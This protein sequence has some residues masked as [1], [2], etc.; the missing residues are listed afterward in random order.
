MGM[1]GELFASNWRAAQSVSFGIPLVPAAQQLLFFLAQV[2]RYRCLYGGPAVSRAIQRYEECWLPLLA[3]FSEHEATLP[4]QPPLDCAWIWHVHRLNPITYARDCNLLFGRLLDV[5]PNSP[6]VTDATETTKALWQERFPY[7]SY[8]LDLAE[9]HHDEHWAPPPDMH[10]MRRIKYDLENAVIRQRSFFYQVSKPHMK[11]ECFLRAAE[12]RYKAFL[13]LFK[14]TDCKFFFVPTYDIDLMWHTHQLNPKAYSED[15]TR[16]LGR[17]LEHD[18]TDTDRSSG[19]KLDEGFRQTSEKWLHNY[20]GV[21]EQAGAMYRGE[22]PAP[23]DSSS[24][25]PSLGT[26]SNFVPIA[27]REIMQ[28]YLTIL[29]A[30]G[31][32]KKQG[33]LQVRLQ[34][35]KKCSAFQLMTP[36]VPL[37]SKPVWMHTW[38]FQAEKSTEGFTLELLR[39]HSRSV[40]QKF[41]GSDVLGH[42]FL[43]WQ[44]LLSTPTLSYSG[45]L[46]LTPTVPSVTKAPSL[47]VSVSLTPPQPA[48]QLLRIINSIPTDDKGHMGMGSFFDR[49]GC[50]LT[51]TVLDHANRQVFIIRTRYSDGHTRTPE[52]EKCIYIHQGG[53]EYRSSTSKKGTAPATVVATASQVVTGQDSKKSLSLQRCWGFCENSSQLI[54]RASTDPKWN[55]RP[56]LELHGNLK[57][58]VGLVCGRK[59]DYEVKGASEDEEGG[60]VTLIRYNLVD[61]S[62]GK[63]TALFNWRTGAMEVSPEESVVLVLLL[64]S[65][66]SKSVM[67]MEGVK[68]RFNQ[69]REPPSRSTETSD[70]W[71]SVVLQ[72]I[73][74]TS[75]ILSSWWEMSPM[76]WSSLFYSP[77]NPMF[78][79]SGCGAAGSCGAGACGGSACGGA[80]CGG[81]GGGGCGGGGGGGGGCGGGGGGGG[82]C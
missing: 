60:F 32:P 43:S 39:R 9:F 53:W 12:Q 35:L 57:F 78:G 16:I 10:K 65:I 44:S 1:E 50:W 82:G 42:T 75:S 24:L 47:Y 40:V 68:V 36:S 73:E 22:P 25:V 77:G 74:L 67:D 15:L 59:L 3:E 54:V 20:G 2:D 6:N 69:G 41:K 4:L 70:E 46:S 79:A 34:V 14:T 27:S 76:L 31:L 81:A 26:P 38:K 71:G 21:Y 72:T 64:S 13:H 8:A 49:R 61:S 37:M 7:E 19:Q 62:M 28:V 58:Q 33:S 48:P 80:G 23:V 63:A 56:H 45:W 52:A 18:D 51:R 66:I 17:V 29:R 11:E 30:D 55:L 5:P